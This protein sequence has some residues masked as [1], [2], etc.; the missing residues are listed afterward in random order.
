MFFVLLHVQLLEVVREGPYSS[1]SYDPRTGLLHSP[2]LRARHSGSGLEQL[3]ERAA[4][5]HIAS[6]APVPAPWNQGLPEARAE[7]HCF[8]VEE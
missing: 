8:V 6:A 7:P 1:E 3:E 5:V 2:S 4:Q